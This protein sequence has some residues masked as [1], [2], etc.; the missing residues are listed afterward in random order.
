M[1]DQHPPDVIGA[2]VR[3]IFSEVLGREHLPPNAS[4]DAIGLD[5]MAMIEVSVRIEETWRIEMPDLDELAQLKIATLDELVELVRKR[6][7][8]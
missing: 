8:P 3:R 2:S 4:L 7:Q 6:V 1:D 5:S